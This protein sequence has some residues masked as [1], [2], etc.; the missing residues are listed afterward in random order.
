MNAYKKKG[1]FFLLSPL[2]G[3]VIAFGLYFTT[4]AIM[5]SQ[6]AEPSALPAISTSTTDYPPLSLPQ[7][8]PYNRTLRIVQVFASLIGTLS[9]LMIF[10]GVPVGIYYMAKGEEETQKPTP[11][12][13]Q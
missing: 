3:F 8:Q 4:R 9:V 12:S 10:V 11:S 2:I 6:L 5:A 13:K 7:E 1:I